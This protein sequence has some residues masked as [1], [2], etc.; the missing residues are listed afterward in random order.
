MECLG[1]RRPGFRGKDLD[2]IRVGGAQ[3]LPA[4][5]GQQETEMLVQ[6]MAPQSHDMMLSL[7]GGD[8][9]RKTSVT[10]RTASEWR[11]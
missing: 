3:G 9:V 6:A 10:I 5:N 4:R 1:T 8:C 2:L 11:G 7:L